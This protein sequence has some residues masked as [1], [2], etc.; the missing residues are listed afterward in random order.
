M[1][2]NV[3]KMEIGT[4]TLVIS[5]ARKLRRKKYTTIVTS[6]T[7]STKVSSVSCSEARIVV[8]RSMATVT[9]ISAGIAASKC[10]NSAFTLSMV[11]MML[12]LGWRNRMT[13][14]EGRPLDI[15]RLRTVLNGVLH[16]GDIR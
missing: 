7:A 12:A 15:P 4:A 8:L 1:A 2:P 3:P 13:R 9:F 5:V 14:T 11:S 6:M 16:V 10:G